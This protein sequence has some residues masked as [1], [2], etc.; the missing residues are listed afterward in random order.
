MTDTL[1]KTL[2]S[3]AHRVAPREAVGLLVGDPLTKVIELP[4]RSLSP[5]DSFM[6][7]GGDI[8]IA[9]ENGGFD[10]HSLDWS[11][12]TLWHTHP[13]GGVGPSR[14]DLRNKLPELNHLVVSITDDGIIP[15]WY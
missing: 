15:T 9:L 8:K 7:T 1:L 4:N 5:S 14:V 13:S 12:V 2:E 10:I 6:V 3:I 11:I